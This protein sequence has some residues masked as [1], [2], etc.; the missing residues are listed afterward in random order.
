[1]EN[2]FDTPI[3]LNVFNRPAMTLQVLDV[4]KKYQVP[5]LYV[6][7]D[8]ARVGKPD[9]IVK[10]N[11]VKSI[12]KRY[13]DWPCQLQTLY[14]NVNLGCGKGPF[15]AISWFFENVEKGIILEDDCI[16]HPDFFM[17]CQELLERYKDD[18]RICHIGG[19][20]NGY[21]V[22]KF[23]YTFASGHYQTWGWATWRRSWQH[24]DY[25]L[26]DFSFSEFRKCVRHYY[27][28]IRQ[29]EYWWNIFDMVKFDRMKDSCWDYQYMFACWK[30]YSMAVVPCVNLVSNI[31]DGDDATHTQGKSDVLHVSVEGILPLRFPN[32][33]ELNRRNDDYMM[34]KYVIPYHYGFAGM[35]NFP[36]RVN[37][38]IKRIT[39]HK[40]S[41]I[42]NHG[43]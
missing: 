27:K 18:E 15:K 6:H 23:S 29:Q 21:K 34:R 30:R 31:G 17:Y 24:V 25:Y 7:C 12:I 26:N 37:V 3:L 2:R 13:I 43:K 19:N 4:L 36:F 1:M 39:G 42:R 20:N 14:E 41:W 35:K 9:D 38:I 32:H 40:G 10:I 8:G 33:I 22:E 28:D 11:E 16:P 5:I